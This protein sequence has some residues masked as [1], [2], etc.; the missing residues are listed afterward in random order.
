MVQSSFPRGSIYDHGA[1]GYARGIF[2]YIAMIWHAY[3]RIEVNYLKIR[4]PG[5]K[6]FVIFPGAFHFTNSAADALFDFHYY[7][8]RILRLDF[9]I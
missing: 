5:I 3:G 2:A 1:L 8:R 9:L 7:Q 4:M 6:S